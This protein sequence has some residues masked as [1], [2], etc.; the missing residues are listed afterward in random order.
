MINL[1][2]NETFKSLGCKWSGSEREA[3]RLAEEE[4]EIIKTKYHRDLVVIEVT[5]TPDRDF[6]W[7]DWA[8]KNARTIAGYV[9]A[10]ARG[11]DSGAIVSREV[12]LLSGSFS[13][14]G[15]VKNFMCTQ[16]DNVV[17]RMEVARGTLGL[18]DAEVAEG[19]Y[20]YKI[21]AKEKSNDQ[22]LK[23]I[24]ALELQIAKL[25]E[26]LND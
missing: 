16:S 17:L 14:G 21:L 22:I 11:R 15:S 9:I 3:P 12:S 4:Y 19:R 1:I 13:S 5:A 10:T 23:E 26:S 6:K 8:Y 2:A 24:E 20:T 18:L 7:Y 25:K